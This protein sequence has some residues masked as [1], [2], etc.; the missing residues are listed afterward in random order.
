MLMTYSTKECTAQ[1]M[2]V[3]PKDGTYVSDQVFQE[4]LWRYSLRH[5]DKYAKLKSTAEQQLFNNVQQK[6]LQEAGKE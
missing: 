3:M 1:M 6:I 2:Q 5:P 4:E